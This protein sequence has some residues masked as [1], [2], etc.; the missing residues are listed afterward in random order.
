[1]RHINIPIFI[2]HLGCP[3][4]CVFCNQK[5]ISGVGSFDIDSVRVQIEDALSS[6]NPTDECEIAFFGGSFT[7]IDFSL[8]VNLL[9]IANEYVASGRVKSI[10]CSTRPDYIDEKILSVLKKYS[11]TVIE[12]G[13]QSV[14]E[15][16]LLATC[17]GH[18]FQAEKRAV[19]LIKSY[20]FKL[21]G[22]MMIGLPH[23]TREDEIK[24][25]EFIVGCGCDM[26]RIYPT[27]VF[28]D[29]ELCRMCRTGEYT[30]LSTEDAVSRSKDA[31]R[32]LQEGGVQ[33]IRIGL[34]D[35]EN[36]HSDKTYFAGPNHPAIGEMVINEFYLEKITEGIRKF[37]KTNSDYIK[38]YVP[39]AHMSKA[40]GQ[41]KRNKIILAERFSGIRVKFLELDT[42]AEYKVLLEKD[43]IEICI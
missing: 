1:M 23:S 43:G 7:G 35:S 3:N 12:L 21:G 15:K 29:T 4:M 38:I 39:R 26:A 2:P 8:M 32:I 27:V 30:P 14:S 9:K 37:P 18:D 41:N 42:L 22:Q 6:V 13:L 33:V 17:R 28:R 25:A 20:G 5:T 40:V 19:E 24:T 31:F 36:L 10:R 11:V 34:C 16:V